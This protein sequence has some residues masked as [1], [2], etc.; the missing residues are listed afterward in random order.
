MAEGGDLSP[1]LM[2]RGMASLC[3]PFLPSEG[4]GEALPSPGFQ[5]PG[6]PPARLHSSPPEQKLG[7]EHREAQR[8][9][10]LTQ[11]THIEH[12]LY[13]SM[14]SKTGIHR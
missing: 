10:L 4:D 14:G 13:A 2:G 8:A 11:H 9:H 5:L 3:P 6:L 1:G 7:P 12:L